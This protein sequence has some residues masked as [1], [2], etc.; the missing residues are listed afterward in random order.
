MLYY[1]DQI[2]DSMKLM[3]LECGILRQKIK[4]KRKE[5]I[6]IVEGVSI[7]EAFIKN[8]QVEVYYIFKDVDNEVKLRDSIRVNYKLKC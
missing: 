1:A 6:K 8:I 2:S 5:I 7:R 3:H 4:S